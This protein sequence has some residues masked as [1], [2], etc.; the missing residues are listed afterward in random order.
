MTTESVA[1]AL[2]TV[3]LIALLTYTAYS[4]ATMRGI[5]RRLELLEDDRYADRFDEPEPV[6]GPFDD[7]DYVEHEDDYGRDDD[8][9]KA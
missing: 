5:E 3:L 1:D 2:T 4:H 9:R 8:Q 6:T 7:A